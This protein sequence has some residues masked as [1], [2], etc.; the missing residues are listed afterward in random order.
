MTHHHICIDFEGEGKKPSGEAPLPNLLGA[1]LPGEGGTKQYHLFLFR[2]ELQPM[3]RPHRLVGKVANR[4]VCTLRE[5]IE[6]L[7]DKAAELDCSLVGYSQHELKMVEH[8]LADSHPTT[9]RA[10]KARWRNVKIDAEQLAR[11]R[12]RVL[13]DKKLN[14]LLTALLPNHKLAAEPSC[15]PAEACRRLVKA[16]TRSTRWRRWPERHRELAEELIRYNRADCVAVWKLLDLVM[17][18]SRLPR[19]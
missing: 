17:R 5:A 14:T 13:E 4:R 15:G 3:T 16:G 11:K 10:F 6:T 12:D 1:L 9:F 8:H 7:L 2:E 19:V 18:N